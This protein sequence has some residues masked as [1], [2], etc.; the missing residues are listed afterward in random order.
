[1]KKFASQISGL[2]KQK[3]D[4]CIDGHKYKSLV[5]NDMILG[6]SLGLKGTPSFIIV[7][8]DGSKPETFL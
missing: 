5:D 4:S 7:K 8:N 3:F 1:M 6:V 2:D